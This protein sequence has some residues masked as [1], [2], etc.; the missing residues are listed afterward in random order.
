M[1]QISVTLLPNQRSFFLQQQ[2]SQISVSSQGVD[3]NVLWDLKFQLIHLQ[4]N[5]NTY[6]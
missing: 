4:S 5:P 3:N 2:L 1:L 6:G